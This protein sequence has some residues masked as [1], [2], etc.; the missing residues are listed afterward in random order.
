MVADV[1]YGG[2]CTIYWLGFGKIFMLRKFPFASE[3]FC[4]KLSLAPP[5]E[6]FP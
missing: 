4:A 5:P 2:K 1:R 6:M 3:L